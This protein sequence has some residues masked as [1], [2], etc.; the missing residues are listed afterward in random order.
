MEFLLDTGASE[1]FMSYRQYESLAAKVMLPELGR[2]EAVVV[3]ADGTL[4]QVKGRM[5]IDL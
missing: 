1:C 4:L 2:E 3:Q 5:T